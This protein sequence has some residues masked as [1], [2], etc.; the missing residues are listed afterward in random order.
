LDFALHLRWP[1]GMSAATANVNG[2]NVAVPSARA[3]AID[4]SFDRLVMGLA[5]P[6]GSF[7]RTFY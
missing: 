1:I 6:C 2:A 3:P 4:D 7:K 5:F